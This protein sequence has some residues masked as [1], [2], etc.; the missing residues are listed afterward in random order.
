MNNGKSKHGGSEVSGLVLP[1]GMGELVQL[2]GSQMFEPPEVTAAKRMAA[3]RQERALQLE[4]R[5]IAL[6]LVP[7][8]PNFATAPGETRVDLALRE[9]DDLIAKTGGGI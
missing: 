7:S 1:S 3:E 6:D 4:R 9:A 8:Q 5:R 2:D